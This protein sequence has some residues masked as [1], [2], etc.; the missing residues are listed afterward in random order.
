MTHELVQLSSG[1][2]K[3]LQGA[4]QAGMLSLAHADAGLLHNSGSNI[5]LRSS[6]TNVFSAGMPAAA[7]H[8]LW[9]KPSLG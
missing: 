3:R 9:R 5:Q 8:Q 6:I 7:R 1:E 2:L 4:L